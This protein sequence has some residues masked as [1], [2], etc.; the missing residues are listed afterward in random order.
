MTKHIRNVAIIVAL[1]AA[2]FFLP[3]GGLAAGL[4]LW[5]TGV[6][7]LGGL[8]WFASRLYREHRFSLYALGDRWRGILYVAVAVAVL[9]ITAST[10]LF[11]TPAG[12]VAWFVLIGAA[13]F[14]VFAVYRESRTY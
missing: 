4:L 1:G 13:S 14:A 11:S 6:L 7:F 2:V 5:L 9:T 8:A 10:E 3:G 12:T